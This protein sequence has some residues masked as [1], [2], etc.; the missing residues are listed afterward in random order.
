MFSSDWND[1]DGP[2]YYVNDP[3]LQNGTNCELLP[4]KEDYEKDYEKD[5][6]EDYEGSSMEDP[7]Y[8]PKYVLEA[9]CQNRTN[10]HGSTIAQET[11]LL[12]KLS[13]CGVGMAWNPFAGCVR[14]WG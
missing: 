13:N 11:G 2:C 1:G 9:C 8:T 6:E 14:V 4:R 7:D 5:Y 3:E 10:C 12:D